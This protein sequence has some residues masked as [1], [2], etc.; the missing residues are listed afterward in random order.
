MWLELLASGAGWLAHALWYAGRAQR[1]SWAHRSHPP[2]LWLS[3]FGR[4]A[5]ALDGEHG[6]CSAQLG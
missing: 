2:L 5:F 4:P 6:L 1:R 3:V